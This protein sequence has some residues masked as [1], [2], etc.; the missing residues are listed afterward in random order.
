MSTGAR[1]RWRRSA[2]FIVGAAGVAGAIYAFSSRPPPDALMPTLPAP[3]VSVG[4]V[5][6]ADLP[7][8]L[9]ALGTVTPLSTVTVKS[10][11]GGYLTAVAFKEGQMVKKG[12]L[13][14]QIDSRPYEATLAQYQGQLIKDQALLRNSQLDLTRQEQLLATDS[15]SQQSF[16]TAKA[17]VRQFEGTVQSDQAQVDAQQLNISYCRIVAPTDGR[18]GLRQ[19]DSGNYVQAAG[20]NGLV[21]ITQIQPISVVFTIPHVQLGPVL[22]RLRAGVALPV[23]AYDSNGTTPLGEGVLD[24]IDNQVDASTGTVKLRAVF[25]NADSELFP[26]QFVNMSLLVDTRHDV[27]LVPTAAIRYGMSG[28]YVYRLH[29]DD[30]V[31]VQRV[32]AG[33]AHDGRTLVLTGL[34]AGDRVVVDGIDRLNDSVKVS[35]RPGTLRGF[36]DR[37]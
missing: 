7:I 24:T 1:G 16:E 21:V 5:A 18:A 35:I 11:I 36:A 23:T 29:G 32:S 9:Q 17:T 31:A 4:L 6:K 10:S 13:L 25:A 8:E 2:M 19:I 15:T 12:D 37:P 20:A 26:N 22:K 34:S 27:L 30:T 33:P 14:A 28:P 3:S